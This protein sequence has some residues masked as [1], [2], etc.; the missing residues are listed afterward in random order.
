MPLIDSHAHLTYPD[1]AGRIDEVLGRCAEAGVER[2]ISIGTSLADA[3]S[4][5]ALARKYPHRVHAAAGFHPHHTDSVSEQDLAAMARLWT[6]PEVVALGEM[7]LD[8]HYDFADRANQR[9]I[10]AGQLKAAA[11]LDK[12]II[13]HAREAFEDVAAMLIDQGFRDRRVVF[14]CFTGTAEEAAAIAERGWR[15]SFTGIVTFPKSDALQA[16]ARDYPTDKLMVETDSPYLSPVPVRSKR[17]NEPAYVA[18]TARFLAALRGVTF[19]QLCAETYGS[20]R[21][22]FGLGSL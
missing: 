14:H 18:H 20:T 6:E 16:I 13:I 15:I 1:F 12:A 19:E 11:F 3:G 7:G 2:V 22:F 4:A 8:Y 10:F 9:K 21:T 5:I 17:P